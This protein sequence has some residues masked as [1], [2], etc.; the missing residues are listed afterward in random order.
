MGC[1]ESFSLN[2]W[3]AANHCRFNLPGGYRLNHTTFLETPL[4]SLINVVVL[5]I[6][7]T[8]YVSSMDCE[9]QCPYLANKITRKH[10][11]CKADHK[12]DS[13]RTVFDI[14]ILFRLLSLLFR[15]LSLLF[16]LLSI[17]VSSSGQYHLPC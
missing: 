9:S 13:I 12:Y 2:C 11:F 6:T 17:S 8:V 7:V 4:F 1:G 10:I 3:A 16:R 5:Y 15:L 14:G